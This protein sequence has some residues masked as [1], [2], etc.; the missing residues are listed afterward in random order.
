MCER[1]A[2]MWRELSRAGLENRLSVQDWFSGIKRGRYF[3][4]VKGNTHTRPSLATHPLDSHG[5]SSLYSCGSELQEYEERY[6]V[7]DVSLVIQKRL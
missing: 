1:A 4:K 7:R 2:A 6:K 3:Q 5:G